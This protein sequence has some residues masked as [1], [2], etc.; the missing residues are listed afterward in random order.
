MKAKEQ[1]T[2]NR[3]KNDQDQ[4]RKEQEDEAKR[5]LDTVVRHQKEEGRTK[6]LATAMLNA[7]SSNKSS[8]NSSCLK[9]L[10]NFQG[11]C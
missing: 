2:M 8:L 3:K 7:A 6:S 10:N 5:R 11:N 9:L 1:L 4:Q